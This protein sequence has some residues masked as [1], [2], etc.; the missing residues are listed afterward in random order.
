MIYESRASATKYKLKDGDT[1]ASIVSGNPGTFATWQ[2]LAMYNWGTTVPREVNRVLRETFGCS[3]VDAADPSATVLAKHPDLSDVEIFLAKEYKQTGLS[4]GKTY[5]AQIK[6]VEPPAAI[7]IDSLD[8][9]FIPQKETCDLQYTLEGLKTVAKKVR[10]EVYGSNYSAAGAWNKGLGTFPTSADKKDVALY[11]FDEQADAAE[12]GSLKIKEWKGTV[13]T[14]DG[15]LGAETPATGGGAPTP[16]GLNV[17][18]SPYTALLKY[19]LDDADKTARLV[20]EPFWPQF[21]A[22]TGALVADSL[23]IHWSVQGTKRLE[24]GNGAGQI[25][26]VDGQG[27][28]V[29]RKPLKAAELAEKSGKGHEHAWASGTYNEP[30]AKNSKGGTTAIVE[31]MPYRV[32]VEAHT[33]AGQANGLALAAMQ[34]E[35]RLYVHPKTHP[36][37]LDPYDA[38]TDENSFQL[39][40][41]TE[42]LYHKPLT[43]GD[44]VPWCKR[45]LAIGGYHAGPVDG[46]AGHAA[47]KLALEEFKRSVP[48]RRASAA[49]D[50]QRFTIDQSVGDDVKDA[51]EDLTTN[52][53]WQR[54]WFGDGSNN[55]DIT[56]QAAQ[57]KLNDPKADMVIWVDDRHVYTDADWLDGVAQGTTVR[58]KVKN[59]PQATKNHMQGY[60]S[61]DNIVGFKAK[62]IPRPW[63]PLSAALTLLPKGANLDTVVPAPSDADSALMRQALGPLRVDWTF[64][65]IDDAP[66]VEANV[67][68]AAYDKSVTR[69]RAHTRDSLTSKKKEATRKDV[70]KKSIYHNCKTDFGGIRP[71]AGYYKAPFGTGKDSLLP[72]SP[73]DDA[74]HEAMATVLHDNLGQ[75]GDDLVTAQIGKGGIFF[76]PSIIGGDGYRVRAQVRFEATGGYKLPNLA[77]LKARYPRPPQAQSAKL[78]VWKKTS[79]RSYVCWS[80]N[81]SWGGQNAATFALFK[82]GYL[83][84][85]YEC[86]DAAVNTDVKTWI[87]DDLAFKNLVRESLK[88]GASATSPDGLRA[89]D[90]VINR[91]ETHLWPWFADANYGLYEPSAP[92]ATMDQARD[93]LLENTINPL[94]YTLSN[95]FGLELAKRIEAKTGKMRGHVIIEMLTSD[96]FLLQQ[97]S[98]GTCNKRYY[99]AEKSAAGGSKNNAACPTPAC[100]GT[101][102]GLIKYNGHYTCTNGHNHEWEDQAAGGLYNG[103][104]CTTPACGGILN[105]TVL[106][107]INAEKSGFDN[108]PA[109]SLGNPLGMAW[110]F[111]G[112]AELWGH[113]SGHCRHM[114]HAG[115][116][117][118]ANGQQHDPRTNSTFNWVGIGETT[119]DGKHWDRA[120]LM[121]YASHRSTYNAA[122]D[123]LALCGKCALKT[124]GWKVS[125][126]ANP[127]GGV[128]DP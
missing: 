77:V 104:I 127:G 70:K 48:Q 79:V 5:V 76:R 61:G 113:E 25:I 11:E 82:P 86:N 33:T 43:R 103:A 52:D 100:A 102:T 87:A 101:L 120:C 7:A 37:D 96:E 29:Y 41:S 17:A 28:I 22:K 69:T 97:Y 6:V 55:S 32:R 49:A 2:D 125:N 98:C 35:V 47:F 36:L 94:F 26:I 80:P 115:N 93:A 56:V 91:D 16:R 59:S 30:D 75:T 40:V 126:I 110:N 112:H 81:N 95:L 53:K 51:L 60:T 42:L 3:K 116:A 84:F 21:D 128:K 72:W 18:F 107:V 105:M 73:Q 27:K 108:I 106:D 24:G 109:P 88:P 63:L 39:G 74:S 57:T 92:N 83:H 1:L 65:E 13:T 90:A 46:D 34:T 20:L 71:A 119:A 45:Q 14:K 19:Y 23:K 89:R 54:P 4:P 12:R 31:D 50:F 85:V 124:R 114:E 123:K 8:R 111:E 66:P 38:T 62:S 15:A 117:P 68:V 58:N 44:G 67:N 78:R 9:W 99:Y 64:D 122:R 118:G 10:F 121:T